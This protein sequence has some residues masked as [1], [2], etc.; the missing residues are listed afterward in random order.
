MA[1]ILNEKAVTGHQIFPRYFLLKDVC[2]PVQELENGA[3]HCGKGSF[4]RA[5]AHWPLIGLIIVGVKLYKYII[6]MMNC[7]THHYMK[8]GVS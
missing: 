5:E 2:D 7:I 1:R 3:E 6:Q 4:L 8:T